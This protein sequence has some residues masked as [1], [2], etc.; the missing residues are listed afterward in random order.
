MSLRQAFTFAARV[1][2]SMFVVVI[3]LGGISYTKA[4]PICWHHGGTGHSSYALIASHGIM[5]CQSERLDR[6]GIPNGR[7]VGYDF[8]SGWNLMGL[9][10]HHERVVVGGPYPL[11]TA[12]GSHWE[13]WCID[14]WLLAA[15]LVLPVL[16]RLVIHPLPRDR[17]G[18]FSM[19]LTPSV[20]ETMD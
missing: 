15:A 5:S 6:P 1:S 10:Y 20:N 11:G 3:I 4:I 7:T 12:I 14:A 8:D 18:G 2:F 16:K 9:H 13:F 17:G 19:E